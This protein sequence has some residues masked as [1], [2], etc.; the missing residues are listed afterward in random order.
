MT[1]FY[2]VL[3]RFGAVLVGSGGEMDGEGFSSAASCPGLG[4][5]RRFRGRSH[6]QSIE[7]AHLSWWDA[8]HLQGALAGVAIMAFALRPPLGR[9]EVVIEGPDESGSFEPGFGAMI[10]S[11]TQAEAEVAP[12]P[13]R[14]DSLQASIVGD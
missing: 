12:I 9:L 1:R 5:K 7:I 10:P 2:L 13:L 6:A 11:P 8:G 3:V 4:K 14:S